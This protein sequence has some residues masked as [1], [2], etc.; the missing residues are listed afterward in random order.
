MSGWPIPA[1]DPVAAARGGAQWSG[2]VPLRDLPGVR[3]RLAALP[4]GESPEELAWRVR[5]EP[6]MGHDPLRVVEVGVEGRAW[7]VCQRTLQPFLQVFGSRSR[8]ALVATDDAA[9]VL[10]VELEPWILAPGDG[11]DIGALLREEVLLALPLVPRAPG[12]PLPPAGRGREKPTARAAQR[13]F[14]ALGEMLR[15]G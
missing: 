14:A 1:I 12:T 9:A 4:A 8:V 15:K 13:P 11:L 7:L 10:P 6:P 2:T 3:D 5:F